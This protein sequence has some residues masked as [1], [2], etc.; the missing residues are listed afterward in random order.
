[1]N[2]QN[3][4]FVKTILNKVDTLLLNFDTGTSD[5]VL[6]QETLKNKIKSSLKSGTNILQIGKKN[7]RVLI[8]IRHSLQAT[9]QMAGLDGIYLME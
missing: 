2:A 6:T 8:F 9:V 5:L 4:I 7:T 1:M 3:T